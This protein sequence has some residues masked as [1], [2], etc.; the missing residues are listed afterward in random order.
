MLRAGNTFLAGT[1]RGAVAPAAAGGFGAAA[2]VAAT[3]VA[4]AVL[5]TLYPLIAKL[6]TSIFSTTIAALSKLELVSP[7]P[8]PFNQASTHC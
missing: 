8:N 5:S 7:F 2:A 3:V 4:L 1:A 6:A